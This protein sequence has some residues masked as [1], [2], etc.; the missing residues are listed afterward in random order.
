MQAGTSLEYQKFVY[1]SAAGGP[2]IPDALLAVQ[3]RENYL[4]LSDASPTVGHSQKTG[5]KNRF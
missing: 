4:D 3:N 5:I 2:I 1:L